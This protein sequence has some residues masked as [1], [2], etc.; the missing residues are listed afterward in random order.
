ML[1]NLDPPGLVVFLVIR[2][3]ADGRDHRRG[4]VFDHKNSVCVQKQSSRGSET[5]VTYRKGFAEKDFKRNLALRLISE[6]LRPFECVISW[7]GRQPCFLP[8][9]IL[10]REERN[11]ENPTRATQDDRETISRL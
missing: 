4:E 8:L 9:L 7:L 6:D 2:L 1:N 5:S 3:K 11:F 10:Y